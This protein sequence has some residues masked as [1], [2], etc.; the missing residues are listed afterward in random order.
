MRFK[1]YDLITDLAE[2]IRQ[3]K[4]LYTKTEGHSTVLLTKRELSLQLR[5]SHSRVNPVTLR[6]SR[7]RTLELEKLVTKPTNHHMITLNQCK[8]HI[9]EWSMYS[10]R[11]QTR[12]IPS[13]AFQILK[14]ASVMMNLTS[15]ICKA[16]P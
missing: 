16:S 8:K 11:L 2:F 3:L 13:D 5:P 9:L 15:D 4:P 1:R 6:V 14:E 7:V 12:Q 10:E